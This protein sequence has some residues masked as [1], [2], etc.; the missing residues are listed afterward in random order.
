MTRSK[1]IVSLGT[2]LI[3]GLALLLIGPMMPAIA[4]ALTIGFDSSNMLLVKVIIAGI[5]A[6][7]ILLIF[8]SPLAEEERINLEEKRRRRARLLEKL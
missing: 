1:G 8:I 6:I 7:L 2:I 3:V 4:D 5:P